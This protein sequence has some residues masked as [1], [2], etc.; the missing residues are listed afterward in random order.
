MKSLSLLGLVTVGVL[1]SAPALAVATVDFSG[2]TKGCFGSSNCNVQNF[3]SN[4]NLNFYGGNFSDVPVGTEIT[5]SFPNFNSL[6]DITL[7]GGNATY[8][9]DFKLQV[10]IFNGS[11]FVTDAVFDA[12]VT[13]AVAGCNGFGNRCTSTVSIDFT[14]ASDTFTY[15]GAKYTMTV[16]NLDDINAQNEDPPITG[17]IN[18]AAVPEPSTWAMMILGFAGIGFAGCRRSRKSVML[19][20]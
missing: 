13:G 2:S 7:G 20:A 8:S 9:T 5:P 6:G 10:A 15:S 12:T 18:V 14:T 17:I 11:T 19:V 1:A 3:S 16:N 4:Q